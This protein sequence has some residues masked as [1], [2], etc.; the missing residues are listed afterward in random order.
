MSRIA[1]KKL[2]ICIFF[3]SLI[4]MTKRFIVLLS[5]AIALSGCGN[6]THY[7]IDGHLEGDVYEGAPVYLVDAATQ[8]PVDSTLLTNGTFRFE[9]ES[10]QPYVAYLVAA[11][12]Y[13][14][15]Q[16]AC[17]VEPGNIYIDLLSD[18]LAGTPLNDKMY[19]F[20]LA[21]QQADFAT[22]MSTYL[23]LYRS[24]TSAEERRMAETAYDSI[25]A[26]RVAALSDAA[27]NTY[28]ENKDNVLGAFTL[29][30]WAT[31]AHPT[32]TEVEELLAPAAE[33]VRTYAPL[34]SILNQL[35]AI[36]STAAGRHYTDIDG[37]DFATGQ[38][39]KLSQ[40]IDGHVALVDF[41]ASWCHPCR[42]EISENLIRIYKQ[43]ATKGLQV[44]GV[45]VWDQ[46]ERHA[47]AVA[48]MGITY[49]QLIDTTRNATT[50]YGING[51][52]QIVLID[53]DGTIIARDLRGDEIEQAVIAAL[54]K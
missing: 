12:A 50:V 27:K 44:V 37:I 54:N 19:A 15:A 32:A 49:P 1:E 4:I 26:L 22:G 35:H 39:G 47:K 30:L 20:T 25:D 41:W 46:P 24:A 40:M 5:A 53:A 51:I 48:E 17:V 21:S 33:T 38:A 28:N 36:E 2:Y 45:D 3:S 34:R 31:E 18:S 8:M 52:P 43:Y 10:K 7:T 23:A 9:G 6:R 29:T 13:G 11:T 14:T 16:S 42:Q